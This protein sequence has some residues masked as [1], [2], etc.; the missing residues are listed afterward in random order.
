MYTLQGVDR[1][2]APVDVRALGEQW[3]SAVCSRD[4]NAVVRLYA[5]DAVLVGT[6]AQRIKQS[7]ADIRTYFE[8]FL[9]KDGLCGQFDSHL[10]QTFPSTNHTWS[11]PQGQPHMVIH[12]GT[13]TFAWRVGQRMT[14][15]PARFTFVWVKLPE[16]WRIANHHSSVLPE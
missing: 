15:V 14:K 9:A 6:V 4:P 13:Y 1:P 11:S 16:G 10:T 5:P 7:R 12:S 8:R 2:L 3:M